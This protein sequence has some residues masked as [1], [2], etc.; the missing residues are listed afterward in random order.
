MANPFKHSPL[1]LSKPG[2]VSLTQIDPAQRPFSVGD[3]EADRK[4][5]AELSERL[6][7]LQ[8][9]LYAA[10]R[11]KLLLVLQGMD[12]SGK[13][14]T[15]RSLFQGIDPLGV[16][17]ISYKV[18]LPRRRSAISCGGIIATYRRWARS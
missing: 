3:K 15:I 10:R 7:Q 5:L 9:R 18:R 8:D 4:R 14:G 6:A 13:N 1:C 11:N 2:P 12:T 16:H 17:A